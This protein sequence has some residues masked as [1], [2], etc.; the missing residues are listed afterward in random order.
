MIKAYL[1]AAGTNS[2]SIESGS[3]PQSSCLKPPNGAA[4]LPRSCR[5]LQPE[6]AVCASDLTATPSNTSTPMLT[7]TGCMGLYLQYKHKCQV[8][9]D[10]TVTC[11]VKWILDVHGHVLK[12][13][14]YKKRSIESISPMLV[15]L[16]PAHNMVLYTSYNDNL[17]C[18]LKKTQHSFE[19][20]IMSLKTHFKFMLVSHEE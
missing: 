20:L 14:H 2:W 13:D 19:K 3:R 8:W 9:N 17:K 4:L 6:Y 12:F 15:C 1:A 18:T 10:E 5:C 16:L 7:T 11:E